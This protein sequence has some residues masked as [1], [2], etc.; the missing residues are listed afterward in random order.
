MHQLP[1]PPEEV[2]HK[3]PIDILGTSRMR[4]AL[5][6]WHEGCFKLYTIHHICTPE[7]VVA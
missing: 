6:T 5:E 4:K 2:K 3:A 7:E 1:L